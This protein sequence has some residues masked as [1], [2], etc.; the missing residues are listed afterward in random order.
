MAIAI[1][2]QYQIEMFYQLFF[3]VNVMAYKAIHIVEKAQAEEPRWDGVAKIT[4]YNAEA[5][6]TDADPFTM[7]S[8]KRVYQGAVASN[9]YTLGTEI[10]IEG[11][12]GFRVEDRMNKRYTQYCGTEAERI[13]VFRWNRKDNITAKLSFKIYDQR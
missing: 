5:G 3:P 7:A 11:L 8:G 1:F 12:G 9:C 10:E 6:Q 4:S 2:N 13:D